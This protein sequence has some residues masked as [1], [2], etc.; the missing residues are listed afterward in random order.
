MDIPVIVENRLRYR[1][2]W[3]LARLLR[4][5][6]GFEIGVFG[7]PALRVAMTTS[8]FEFTQIDWYTL[9]LSCKRRRLL[10]GV[11][12]EIEPAR[13]LLGL[14]SSVFGFVYL[15]IYLS[16]WARMLGAGQLPVEVGRLVVDA[17]RYRDSQ[18]RAHRSPEA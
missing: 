10:A 4:H 6:D 17:R 16:D 11:E 9:T 5:E 3:R 15:G 12:R 8:G 1:V 2:R 13:A 7:H 18:P 14:A